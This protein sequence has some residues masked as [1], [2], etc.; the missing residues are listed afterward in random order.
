MKSAKEE[1]QNALNELQTLRCQTT[2]QNEEKDMEIKRYYL[3]NSLL[4]CICPHSID[5]IC[6]L[7][8]IESFL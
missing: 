7:T 5:I 3:P 2:S 1:A 6:R 4:F 8:E